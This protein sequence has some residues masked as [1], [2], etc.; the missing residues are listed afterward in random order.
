VVV[1][2]L[3]RKLKRRA[4]LLEAD[5]VVEEVAAAVEVVAADAV[6]DMVKIRVYLLEMKMK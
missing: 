3:L 4:I 2:K 6:E 5:M 1:E